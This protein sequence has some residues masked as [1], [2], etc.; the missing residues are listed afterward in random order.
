MHKFHL[1]ENRNHACQPDTVTL[2]RLTNPLTQTNS[3]RQV[4]G[5]AYNGERAGPLPTAVGVSGWLRQSFISVQALSAL[6]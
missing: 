5:K 6:S 1:C 2:F 3:P 4:N